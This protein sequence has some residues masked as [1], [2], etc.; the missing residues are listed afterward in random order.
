MR[1]TDYRAKDKDISALAG[2]T[3]LHMKRSD[4]IE[5]RVGRAARTV[6][7]R[8]QILC[9]ATTFDTLV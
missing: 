8:R 4:V 6:V 3:R 9:H 1:L 5:A 2:S 7:A